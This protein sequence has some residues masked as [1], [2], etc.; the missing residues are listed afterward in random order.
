MV[1]IP[2]QPP[3][4]QITA[5]GISISSLSQMKAFGYLE[6]ISLQ[7]EFKGKN[8]TSVITNKNY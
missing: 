2:S 4:P 5:I 3:T 1:D 6:K 8:V 7:K